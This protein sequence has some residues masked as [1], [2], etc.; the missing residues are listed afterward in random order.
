[1]EAL[2]VAASCPVC[3]LGNLG[4]G[5]YAFQY[6]VSSF[7][8]DFGRCFLGVARPFAERGFVWSDERRGG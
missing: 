2:W 3:L 5:D 4:I 1:M 6:A 8:L 7:P